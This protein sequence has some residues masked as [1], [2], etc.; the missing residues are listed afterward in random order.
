MVHLWEYSTSWQQHQKGRHSRGLHGEGAGASGT[1]WSPHLCSPLSSICAGRALKH[2]VCPHAAH[3]LHCANNCVH[4][5]APVRILCRAHRMSTPST[6]C[7]H[8]SS[9]LSSGNAAT[10]DGC[11]GASSNVR[12]TCSGQGRTGLSTFARFLQVL[13]RRHIHMAL[14]RII[15]NAHHLHKPATEGLQSS[16]RL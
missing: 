2:A 5:Q 7:P 12:V 6:L 10:S 13:S 14:L 9:P 16:Q 4:R 1:S 11:M 3:P 8:L 15:V